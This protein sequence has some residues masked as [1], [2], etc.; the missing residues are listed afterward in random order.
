MWGDGDSVFD[1]N[2]SYQKM[3]GASIMHGMLE[4]TWMITTALKEFSFYIIM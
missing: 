3:K 2:S 4:E 1:V